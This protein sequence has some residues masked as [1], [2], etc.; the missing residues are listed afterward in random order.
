MLAYGTMV[1][2]AQAAAE[3][4]GVDAEMIDLRTLMPLDIDA[5]AARSRRPAAA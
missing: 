1:H 2:V 5:I 4:S 3:E